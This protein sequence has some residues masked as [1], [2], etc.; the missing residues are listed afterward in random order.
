MIVL[1]VGQRMAHVINRLIA[2][3]IRGRLGVGGGPWREPLF[4]PSIAAIAESNRRSSPAVRDG[5]DPTSFSLRSDPVPTPVSSAGALVR[6]T[7]AP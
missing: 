4:Y 7:N 1:Q 3:T 2:F 6:T 5:A